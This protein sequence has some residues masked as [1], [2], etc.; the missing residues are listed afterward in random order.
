LTDM[1]LH[2]ITRIEPLDDLLSHLITLFESS[3]PARIRS[4]YLGG[5]Y[6][7]GTAVGHDSSPNSSDV[8]LFVIFRGTVA[9][10]ENA[11]FE[12]LV[13]ECR[14]DLPIQID[15]HA[16]SEDDLLGQ[17]RKGATQTSFLNALIRV[18]GVLVYGEDLRTDLPPVPFSQYVL[19]VIE[20]GVFHLVFLARENVLLIRWCSLSP[21]HSPTLI[22]RGS[23]MAMMSYPHIQRLLV[24]P[25]SS[26]PLPHGLQHSF[27]P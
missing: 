13:A 4:Y 11:T 23:F 1:K 7:D 24:A 8:D 21:F 15:A 25:V 20:S 16:Y 19:D 5:S 12:R 22:P 27:S 26:S 14:R 6:S 9:S 17:P 3:F 2:A 10:D 18:A